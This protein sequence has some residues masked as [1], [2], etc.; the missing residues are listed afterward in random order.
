M[1]RPVAID[2]HQGPRPLELNDPAK[3]LVPERPRAALP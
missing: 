3:A 1:A 2:E